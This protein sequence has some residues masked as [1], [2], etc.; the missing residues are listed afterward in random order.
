M[1]DNFSSHASSY[2]RFRPVYPQQLFDFLIPLVSQK[3]T[4]WD[5]GCGNGQ[6]ASALSAYFKQVEATDISQKQMDHAVKKENIFYREAPAEN[7]LIPSGSVN[8]ITVAQAIHWF[9]FEAFYSEARRVAAPGAL[10][11]IW[12]YNLLKV[13]SAADLLIDNLYADVLGDKYWDEERRYVEERYL[14][15]PFPFTEIKVPDFEIEVS[16]SFD[17]L[18]G[19]LNSWS[20]VQHYIRKNNSNPIDQFIPSLRSAWGE[21]DVLPVKFPLF[22]RLGKIN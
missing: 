21:S 9:N 5:C 2:A 13:N 17:H 14:T 16:W 6:V 8:L 1:K 4:A 19:Y 22:M 12:C 3:D 7:T 18:L 11:A 15:I 20:A 10:L